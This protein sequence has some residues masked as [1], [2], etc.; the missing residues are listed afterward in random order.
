MWYVIA[1]LLVLGSLTLLR[2]TEGSP[3][4]SWKAVF[5]TGLP[6]A[7]V[8]CY[9]RSCAFPPLP[10]PQSRSEKVAL[11]K[12]ELERTIRRV[13][14]V[15]WGR[16]DE[17]IIQMDFSEEKSREQLKQIAL[18]VGVT[19]AHFMRTWETNRVMVIMTINGGNRYAAVYDTRLG[20]IE[21]PDL[22]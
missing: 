14:G 17:G 2:F 1:C 13:Q 21:E 12:A 15:R 22:K 19:T 20:I 6:L 4:R 9:Y 18:S 11:N 3:I 8:V 10:P 5:L 16:I 7:F